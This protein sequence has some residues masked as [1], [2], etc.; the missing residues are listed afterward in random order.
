MDQ[1]T[2][3]LFTSLLDLLKQHEELFKK[4]L[5]VGGRQQD[6]LR[7]NNIELL[8]GAVTAINEVVD[9]LEVLEKKRL[10]VQNAAELHL[11]LPED[12]SMQALL[13]FAPATLVDELVDSRRLLQHSTELF[14]EMNNVNQVMTKNA[15]RFN[16]YMLKTL[17]PPEETYGGDGTLTGAGRRDTLVNKTI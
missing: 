11:G 7:T 9:Q 13:Q 15:I 14:R 17:L 10:G 3:D 4:L 2:W 5:Q 1:R 8:D 6:A 12:S 16:N